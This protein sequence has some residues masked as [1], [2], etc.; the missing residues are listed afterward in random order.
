M[1]TLEPISIRSGLIYDQVVEAIY[2]ARHAPPSALDGADSSSDPSGNKSQVPA[3]GVGAP[4]D[5]KEMRIDLKTFRLFL[6]EVASWARDEFVVSNGFQ[7]RVE[8]KVPDHETVSRLFHF[9]DR[10]GRGTLTL[11]VRKIRTGHLICARGPKAIAD[12][13]FRAFFELFFASCDSLPAGYRDWFRCGHVQRYDVQ[14]RM[15]L[16]LAFSR[17][18]ISDK[19]RGLASERVITGMLTAYLSSSLVEMLRRLILFLNVT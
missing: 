13:L 5:Y 4:Q 17:S 3:V 10:E 11:Q 15:V 14:H 18:S 8:R 7:E 16:Q 9:W 6:G 1:L 2:R 12:Y 19:G